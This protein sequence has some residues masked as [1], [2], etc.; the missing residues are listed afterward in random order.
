MEC[1][2]RSPFRAAWRLRYARSCAAA[3]SPDSGKKL[4]DKLEHERVANRVHFEPY[5]R[6]ADL[7]T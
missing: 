5:P 4:A 3:S 7:P 1:H 2:L 6:V